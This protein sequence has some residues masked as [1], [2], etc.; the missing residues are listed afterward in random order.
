[1]DAYGASLRTSIV[2]GWPAPGRRNFVPALVERLQRG[3]TWRGGT[4]VM[5]SPVYVEH[6]VDGIARLVADFRPG[7]HHV[8]GRDW[9][10]MYDFARAVAAEFS[11]DPALVL[12]AEGDP[13]SPDRLGLDMRDDH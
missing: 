11:L 2:Y 3:E 6:L 12:P 4:D 9:V 10:S 7:I 1:M 8:A 13:G 5:R